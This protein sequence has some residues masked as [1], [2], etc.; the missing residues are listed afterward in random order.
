[1][2]AIH[3]SADRLPA[4]LRRRPHR[5]MR[6]GR[7]GLLFA[8]QALPGAL[9]PRPAQLRGHVPLH[10]PRLPRLRA[11]IHRQQRRASRHPARDC[12][13]E[14]LRD[15]ETP[16]WQAMLPLRAHEARRALQRRPRAGLQ[17]NRPGPPLRRRGGDHPHE[18]A[19]R[20][21]GQNDDAQAP[22][23]ELRGHGTHSPSL[24]GA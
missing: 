22:Q 12:A 24:P 2:G 7:Q 10:G 20:R 18:R 21:T 5:R 15:C 17:Q 3:Q 9:P 6:L 16:G 8:R 19:L 14:H 4:H 13:H 1:M 23:H 11:P